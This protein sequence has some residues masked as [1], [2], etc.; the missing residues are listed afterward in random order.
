M[1]KISSKVDKMYIIR[2]ERRVFGK[3]VYKHIQ[4]NPRSRSGNPIIQTDLAYRVYNVIAFT[5]KDEARSFM[6]NFFQTRVEQL[7]GDTTW[8]IAE[9]RPSYND[10]YV[11]TFKRVNTI[12]GSCYTIENIKYI[13]NIYWGR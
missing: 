11:M 10:D 2:G 3:K 9:Y 8:K 5:N 6:K 1:F 13:K 4:F 12:Y 7:I